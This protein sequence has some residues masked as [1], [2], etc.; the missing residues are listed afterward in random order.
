MQRGSTGILCSWDVENDRNIFD[1]QAYIP[2]LRHTH[3]VLI[4]SAPLSH[5]TSFTKLQFK[6]KII[7]NSKMVTASTKP[8]WVRDPVGLHRLQTHD[9]SWWLPPPPAQW[10]PH[11]MGSSQGRRALDGE[12]GFVFRFWWDVWLSIFTSPGSRQIYKI[13]SLPTPEPTPPPLGLKS[14]LKCH[15]L[16]EASPDHPDKCHSQYRFYHYPLFI[17]FKTLSPNCDYIL[18][19]AFAFFSASS[20]RV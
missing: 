4:S 16:T 8:F 3:M 7:K 19:C 14:Q 11:W 15:L 12:F 5:G 1:I 2:T 18:I 17:P 13:I 10:N 20:T 9:A 6:D